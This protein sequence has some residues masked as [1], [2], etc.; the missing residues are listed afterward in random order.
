MILMPVSGAVIGYFTNWL[1]IRMLFRPQKEIR[2]F[3]RRVPFTPGLIPK[4]RERLSQKV[5]ETVGA[6]ILTEEVLSGAFAS[7]ELNG[8]LGVALDGLLES[9]ERSE[10]TVGELV[11]G[12]G[13][14]FDF[15][16][17]LSGLITKAANDER[18]AD[19]VS[20]FAVKKIRELLKNPSEYIDISLL[21][22]KLRLEQAI[23]ENGSDFALKLVDGFFRKAAEN[24]SEIKS[25]VPE[26]MI[27]G[28][29]RFI[30]SKTPHIGVMLKNFLEK[31]P[32]IDDRLRGLLAKMIHENFGKVVSLFIDPNKIYENIKAGLY[33]YFEDPENEE[34]ISAKAVELMNT[35]LSREVAE[36]TAKIPTGTLKELSARLAGGFG[37]GKA[38]DWLESRWSPENVNLHEWLL[39]AVPDYEDR[40]AAAIKRKIAEGLGG[41]AS[42]VM[43]EK[44]DAVL[45][46]L[47]RRRV[48][49]LASRLKPEHR[50]KLKATVL[51][52][53][54]LVLEK[55]GVSIAR[56][57]DVQKLVVDKL[58]SFEIDEAEKIIVSVVG[59]ELSAIT[60]L[61]GVLGFVI[62][63]V[64]MLYR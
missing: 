17:A 63:F 11:E 13:L 24:H 36:V 56:S 60:W 35:Q 47:A 18:L 61:G 26:E 59:R 34:I 19:A 32:G 22:L 39:K 31:N 58:D 3:G 5:G 20:G 4:E 15:R 27:S 40:L 54:R 33:E 62:G 28:A 41:E 30:R 48:G 12:A 29:E 7:E 8:K 50:E 25:F 2:I 64:P 38:I 49:E 52:L 57:L 44:A 21:K 37:A 23:S 51:K 14:E 45:E 10:K 1:A 55:G 43:L 6:H 9:L 46:Q 53:G 42:E 16:G